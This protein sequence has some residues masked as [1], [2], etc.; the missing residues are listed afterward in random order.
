M[1]KGI[2]QILDDCL[3]RAVFTGRPFQDQTLREVSLEKCLSEYQVVRVE[4]EPLLKTA[5]CTR[6]N[7]SAIAPAAEFNQRA[8]SNLLNRAEHLRST[9]KPSPYLPGLNWLEGLGRL[10]FRRR[11]WAT[12]MA[13]LLALFLAGGTVAASLNASPEQVLYPV[14]LSTEQVQLKLTA[15]PEQRARLYM[16]FAGR[17][18]NEMALIAENEEP[19]G[20]NKLEERLV[21]SLESARAISEELKA[22]PLKAAGA[23]KIQDELI[24]NASSHI[25]TLR[26]SVTVVPP[27]AGKRLEI[28]IDRTLSG[29]AARPGSI[30]GPVQKEEKPATPEPTPVRTPEG[31][32]FPAGPDSGGRGWEIKQK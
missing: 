25:T 18:V 27:G 1:S 16:K 8:L 23:Q 2:V 14:K 29:F 3:D 11:A 28:V 12:A 4:L 13:G 30:N 5:L 19:E 22:Q 31:K 10:V 32:A 17:R 26:H 15:D 6:D 9:P 21:L 20:M 24:E 7:F